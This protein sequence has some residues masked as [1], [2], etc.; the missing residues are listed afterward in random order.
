[1]RELRG[2][3]VIHL[4]WEIFSHLQISGHV[5]LLDMSGTSHFWS[6]SRSRREKNFGPGPGPGEKKILVPVAVPAKKSLMSWS[7]SRQKQILA[8]AS[9]QKYFRYGLGPKK[10][11]LVLVLF[12]KNFGAGPSEKK[13]CSRS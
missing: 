2:Q 9:S 12:R 6:R 7:R 11:I 5:T 13:F 1:V 4:L 3:V 8:E 10:N